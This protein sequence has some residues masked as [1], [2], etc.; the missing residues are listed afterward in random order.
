MEEEPEFVKD[1]KEKMNQTS[2]F[3]KQVPKNTKTRFMELANEEDFMGHY[4]FLLKYLIDFHDGIISSGIEHLEFEI[5][6]LRDRI[7]ALETKPEEK[8]TRTMLSGEK[9]EVK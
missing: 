2:L 1:I 9:R 4:G 6:Q 5:I 3:I 7:S 8:K